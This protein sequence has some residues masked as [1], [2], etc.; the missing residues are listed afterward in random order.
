[1]HFKKVDRVSGLVIPL[2]IQS[3]VSQPEHIDTGDEIALHCG[4]FQGILEA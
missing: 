3:R 4:T 1:M 2:S